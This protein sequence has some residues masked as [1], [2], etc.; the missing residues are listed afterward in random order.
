MSD[1]QDSPT[2][3]PQLSFGAVWLWSPS[4]LATFEELCASALEL[5]DVIQE[6][7]DPFDVLS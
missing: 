3:V 7:G 1:K 6:V 5:G 2:V 4:L